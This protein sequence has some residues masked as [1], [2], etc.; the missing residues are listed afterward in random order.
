MIYFIVNAVTMKSIEKTIVQIV[1]EA[2]YNKAK[3]QFPTDVE[4]RMKYLKTEGKIKNSKEADAFIAKARNN[5]IALRFEI[6]TILIVLIWKY[7]GRL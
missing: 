3:K 2:E 1:S 7:M 5:A 6:V 4:K